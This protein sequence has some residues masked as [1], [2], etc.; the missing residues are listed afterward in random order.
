MWGVP[1]EVVVE[2]KYCWG[3]WLAMGLA[4]SPHVNKPPGI[5]VAL[6]PGMMSEPGLCP[7]GEGRKRGLCPC[8]A[9]SAVAGSGV[10]FWS[11][12]VPGGGWLAG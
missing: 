5:L 4:G 10:P 2:G 9:G 3:A 7:S 1:S 8:A 6:G 12:G 11:I